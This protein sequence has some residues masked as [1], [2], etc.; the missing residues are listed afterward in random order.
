MLFEIEIL[1]D[2]SA[3]LN[4]AYAPFAVDKFE[5]DGGDQRHRHETQIHMWGKEKVTSGR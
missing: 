4:D 3:V 1:D 2:F 5:F